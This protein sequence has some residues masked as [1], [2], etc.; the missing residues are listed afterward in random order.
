MR[1]NPV[2]RRLR[3]GGVVVGTFVFEFATTGIARLAAGAGAEFV[4]FDM[5]HT[6]GPSVSAI[7]RH[8]IRLHECARRRY[9]WPHKGLGSRHGQESIANTLV[10]EP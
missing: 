2:K 1:E 8:A 4:V 10:R 7:G 6:G 5:E 9:A 3:D